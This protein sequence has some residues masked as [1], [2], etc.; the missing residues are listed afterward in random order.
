MGKPCE[1]T[2]P[3]SGIGRHGLPFRFCWNWNVKPAGGVWVVGFPET[4][5]GSLKNSKACSGLLVTSGRYVGWASADPGAGGTRVVVRPVRIEE[6]VAGCV[7]RIIDRTEG[8]NGW[9]RGRRARRRGDR[10]GRAGGTIVAVEVHP[11]KG[12]GPR[13]RAVCVQGTTD[14]V[15]LMSPGVTYRRIRSTGRMSAPAAS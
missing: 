14:P 13:G 7:R 11:A 2:A 1:S 4:I 6:V 5:G 8:A 12:V 3:S 9:G 10:S 15:P